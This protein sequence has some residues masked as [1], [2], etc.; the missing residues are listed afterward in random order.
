MSL[1]KDSSDNRLDFPEFFC[2]S[3]KTFSDNILDM[4]Q[5][6]IEQIKQRLRTYQEADIHFNEP[7]FSQQ[8]LL[9]E[10]KRDDVIHNLLQP[11]CLDQSTSE[12]GKYG[13][14]VHTLH[15]GVSNTRT[16]ILPTIFDP[17]CRKG[18]YILTYIMRYRRWRTQ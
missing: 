6:D 17:G 2:A 1:T 7:H 14:I 4:P 18:L 12:T 11:D 16:M 3:R 8:L 9:R 10:G 15:F 13:D 5:E